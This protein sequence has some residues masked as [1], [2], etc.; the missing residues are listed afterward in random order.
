ME[1]LRFVNLAMIPYLATE[2]R[3]QLTFICSSNNMICLLAEFECAVCCDCVYSGQLDQGIP[4]QSDCLPN[5]QSSD[6][7]LR[8]FCWSSPGVECSGSMTIFE[9]LRIT[10]VA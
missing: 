6:A 5:H 8:A 4:T 7:V 10:M 9:D 1:Q 3:T 2:I